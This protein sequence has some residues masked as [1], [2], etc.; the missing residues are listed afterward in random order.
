MK[1]LSVKLD[2]AGAASAYSLSAQPIS[3]M[4]RHAHSDVCFQKL[5]GGHLV[6]CCQLHLVY[7]TSRA[8]ASLESSLYEG[9]GQAA[10]HGGGAAG[11]NG[12]NV[13]LHEEDDSY[14]DEGDCL[15]ATLSHCKFLP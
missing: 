15:H 7:S 5:N 14:G 10:E 2:T 11:N 8:N 4:H 6:L 9:H 3:F 13:K 1:E 12:Q